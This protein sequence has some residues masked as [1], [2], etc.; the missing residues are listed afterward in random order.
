L[1]HEGH[2]HLWVPDLQSGGGGIQTFSN[3]M[4]KALIEARPAAALTLFAKNDTVMPPMPFRTAFT[5]FFCAGWCPERLRTSVFSLMI[6]RQA[7][8]NRP[9]FILSTHVNFTRAAYLASRT[10]GIP[11]IAVAHGVDTW[12]KAGM[13]LRKP[14]KHAAAILAVSRFT[15]ERLCREVGLPPE[16]VRL[17]PNTFEPDAFTPG[18]KP[19]YL[20]KRYGLKPDEPVILTVSRLAPA[21]R[22]KGY[23]QILKALPAIRSKMPKVR[24]IIGGRGPDRGRILELIQ[25]L[26]LESAVTLTGFIPQPEL[27]DHYNLCDVF[28]MPSKGEGFGIVYLEAMACGKA[29]LAGNKDGSVDALKDGKLGVLIDP[30]NVEEIAA[31]LILMLQKKHSNSI[32]AEPERLRHMVTETFGYPR[33]ASL[34][35]AQLDHV[36]CSQN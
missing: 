5:R 6:L 9:Q 35:K 12:G 31:N 29:V 2:I 36:E 15:A 13:R 33:F 30:D 32:L 18:P 23:D 16:R 19:H 21:E 24:Y 27:V 22:Y 26:G 8:I 10:M 25:S 7:Q 20:L 17:L 11:Y 28:A 34:V 14:L 3:F 4:L 1:R